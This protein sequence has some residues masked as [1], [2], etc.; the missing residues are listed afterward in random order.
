MTAPEPDAPNPPE[1]D[2]SLDE[3]IAAG[4]ACCGVEPDDQPADEDTPS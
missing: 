2:I 3:W 4:Q 1:I